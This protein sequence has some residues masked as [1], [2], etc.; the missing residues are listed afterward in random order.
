MKFFNALAAIAA[1]TFLFACKQSAT[2]NKTPADMTLA[3]VAAEPPQIAVADTAAIPAGNGINDADKGYQQKTVN[4]PAAHP[5][6]DKQIIKNATLSVS[7]EDYKK[8]STLVLQQV[9]ASGGYIANEEQGQSEYKIEN[10]ITIKVPVAQF[11]ALIN[12]ITPAAKAV[13]VRKI[14]SEDVSAEVV[15]TKGRIQ[16]KKAMRE[17]YLQLMSEAKKMSDVLEVQAEINELQE[18]M[19]TAAGRVQYLIHSAA[20]GTIQLTYYQVLNATASVD[21]SPSFVTKLGQ[22]FKSGWLWLGEVLI[23]VTAFWPLWLAIIA[24]VIGIKK[25]KTGMVKAK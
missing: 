7:V 19:E 3:D 13:D 1:S 4:E 6:W 8:F 5:D 22:S 16:T 24:V 17:R 23:A 2:N 15:D 14:N 18:Q 20:Y 25:F 12:S 11:E 10:S 9:K 21:A